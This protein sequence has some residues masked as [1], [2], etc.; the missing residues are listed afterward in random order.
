[1]VIPLA[2]FLDTKPLY[3]TKFDPNRIKKAYNLIKDKIKHP[4]R[5]QIIGTNGKGST[6]RAL[7]Y[8]AYKSK[9]KVGHFSSP[10]IIDFKERFWINGSFA[11]DEILQTAHSKL[12]YLLGKKIANSLSYFEYQAL[13]AF[14]LFE[15]CN[16]QVIEAGLGGEYDAT[17][18]AN[19]NLHI[20]M[21]IDFDHSDF[22]G[23]SIKQIA[24]TKLNA[25]QKK[26]LI[27]FQPNSEV[28]DIAK[29]ILKQK[30]VFYIEDFLKN[31]QKTFDIIK[32]IASKK[33]WPNYL[34]QNIFSAVCALNI[35]DIKYDLNELNNLKLF[36]R[37]YKIKKNVTV[38]VG[39]NKL[40]ARAIA[41]SL[42]KRVSLI[43]NILSDKDA[44]EVLKI[45]KPKINEVL[46]IKI[47]T[48]RAIKEERLIEILN[49][50]N[51]KY[52]YFDEIKDNKEYLVFGSFY[53]VEAFLKK[54]N[55]SVV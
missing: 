42:E 18:V 24:T 3:Y 54:L 4:K 37:F 44:I 32:Y 31:S 47:N 5:V 10:H 46:I 55:Y 16:L 17:S 9:F 12:Y 13:L 45:L 52:S 30:E 51:I 23:D 22:L 49:S 25:I 6:G 2:K 34:V 41:N 21:P 1:M 27:S 29:D 50:L 15:N 39:H 43:F 20:I 14:V 53:T 33:A 35:L 8:L 7:A 40:A 48:K 11:N 28:L 36:G 19:Y 26:A 38:D